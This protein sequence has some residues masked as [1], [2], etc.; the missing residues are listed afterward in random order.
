[1]M[2]FVMITVLTFFNNYFLVEGVLILLRD[3]LVMSVCYAEEKHEG[4]G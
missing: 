2:P 4:D 1:M 3:L